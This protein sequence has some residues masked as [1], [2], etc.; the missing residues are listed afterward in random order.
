MPPTS[1]RAMSSARA[2]Q[3]GPPNSLMRSQSDIGLETPSRNQMQ[4]SIN[5]VGPSKPGRPSG[6]PEPGQ[7]RGIDSEP[8]GSYSQRLFHGGLPEGRPAVHSESSSN[9]DPEERDRDL[10]HSPWTLEERG[11]EETEEGD[12][13]NEGSEEGVPAEHEFLFRY[14]R[15]L[16]STDAQ[17][18]CCACVHADEQPWM[19]T[20]TRNGTLWVY[21]TQ[22][23]ALDRHVRLEEGGDLVSIAFPRSEKFLL[24]VQTAVLTCLEVSPAWPVIGQIPVFVN[25]DTGEASEWCCVAFSPAAEEVDHVLGVAG[26]GLLLCAVSNT[27]IYVLDYAMGVSEDMPKRAHTLVAGSFTRPTC[28]SFTQDG[29]RIACGHSDGEVQ[30]WN[31][32][33]LHPEKKV[34]SHVGAIRHLITSPLAASYDAR[35][36]SCGDDQNLCVWNPDYWIL[37]QTVVDKCLGEE[38]ITSIAFSEKGTWLVTASEKIAVWRITQTKSGRVVASIHQRLPFVGSGATGACAIS[39]AAQDGVMV[40]GSPDGCLGLWRR[41]SGSPPKLDLPDAVSRTAS[42]NCQRY[43]RE[44]SLLDSE[45]NEP[46]APLL[47]TNSK[48][49][50]RV[51]MAPILDQGGSDDDTLPM[52]MASPTKWSQTVQLRQVVAEALGG[53]QRLRSASSTSGGSTPSTGCLAS[54]LVPISGRSTPQGGLRRART[55]SASALLPPEMVRPETSP[56]TYGSRGGGLGRMEVEVGWNRTVQGDRAAPSLH[57]RPAPRPLQRRYALEA[58]EVPTLSPTTA[59]SISAARSPSQ[60]DISASRKLKEDLRNRSNHGSRPKR[61]PAVEFS[62]AP[63]RSSMSVPAAAGVRGGRPCTSPLIGIDRPA[64]TGKGRSERPHALHASAYADV[65]NVF[66]KP[67]YQRS[68]TFDELRR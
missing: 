59:T 4:F 23:W 14:E 15:S 12:D 1:T 61:L 30:V 54:R 27:H 19:V 6:K 35:F 28:V 26:H 57:A 24:S 47:G 48:P 36:V 44:H 21:N 56:M 2:P 32:Y 22:S 34:S 31:A 20:G 67:L 43:R 52:P 39:F 55:A 62:P 63:M 53:S 49:M 3:S 42:H 68:N 65:D 10:Y 64:L 66:R 37:E 25:P 45:E 11:S 7:P 51:S 46:V 40:A 13:D 41:F 5:L 38:G 17:I 9:E 60:G 58:L 33:T 8:A 29:N 50:Q 16:I 18:T